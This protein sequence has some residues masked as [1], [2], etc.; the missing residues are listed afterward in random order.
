MVELMQEVLRSGTA[1]AARGRG[2]TAPAAAKTGTSHDGWFAGFTSELL[3]IVW[4]GFDDNKDLKLEG[5]HSALPIWTEFMKRAAEYREYR[6]MKPFRAPDGIVS[7][8]IDPLSA[9]LAVAGCPGRRAEVFIGGTQPVES[10]PLHGGAQQGVTYAAGWETGAA[11]EETPKLKAPAA[12][13]RPR[14]AAVSKAQSAPAP[15]P[16]KPKEKAG[17][18]RR[19]LGIFK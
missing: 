9:K 12:P 19:V 16:E 5:A 14:R 17:L 2:F 10:C 1:V 18:W 3:C 4:V 7:V 13:A 11:A 8:E 15:E 6:N